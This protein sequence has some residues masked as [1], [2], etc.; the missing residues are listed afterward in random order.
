MRKA[1]YL[2]EMDE[3]KYPDTIICTYGQGDER[4]AGELANRLVFADGALEL[5]GAAV[6]LEPSPDVVASSSCK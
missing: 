2:G 6:D 3:A 5:Q 1:V 4:W